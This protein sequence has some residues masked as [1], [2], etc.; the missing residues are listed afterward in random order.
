MCEGEESED[1][2][3]LS[4]GNGVMD[5][6][7]YGM[8]SDYVTSIPVG[9]ESDDDDD[10]HSHS[11]SHSNK[12]NRVNIIPPSS[13]VNDVV[14]EDHDPLAERRIPRIL[15]RYDEYRAKGLKRKISPERVDPFLEGNSLVVLELFWYFWFF[16][17][18]SHA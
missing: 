9:E 2:I 11:H 18:H 15:D 16:L 10:D 14:D 13:L 1:R 17:I 4:A 3:P 7:I 8:F 6:G 12:R 5:P